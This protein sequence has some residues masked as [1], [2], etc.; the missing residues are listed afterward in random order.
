MKTSGPVLGLVVAEVDHEQPLA[1]VDLRRG[2]SDA[3]RLVHRFEHVV[4]QLLEER[5]ADFARSDALRDLTQGRVAVF[6]DLA[7][8]RHDSH[9]KPRLQGAVAGAETSSA[10]KAEAAWGRRPGAYRM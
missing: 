5:I 10:T 7:D 9:Y 3:R 4:D 8:V 6:D 1:D 2:E